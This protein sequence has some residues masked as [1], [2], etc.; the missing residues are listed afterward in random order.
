MNGPGGWGAR[1]LNGDTAVMPREP[2]AKLPAATYCT[3]PRG[4]FCGGGASA[5]WADCD[6]RCR[7]CRPPLLSRPVKTSASEDESP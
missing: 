3:C 2:A 6:A 7:P 1:L 4:P 5:D